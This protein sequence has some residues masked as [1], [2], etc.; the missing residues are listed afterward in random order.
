MTRSG[1]A[2]VDFYID[3]I[4]RERWQGAG[5]LVLRRGQGNEERF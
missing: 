3:F 1:S 2:I 5:G 4:I